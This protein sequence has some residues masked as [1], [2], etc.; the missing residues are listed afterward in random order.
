M[1]DAD[2]HAMLEDLLA[3]EQAYRP[4]SLLTGLHRLSME[5][6][7][8]F[9]AGQIPLLESHLYGSPT[10][11]AAV[12]GRAAAWAR[13]R[14]LKAEAEPAPAGGARVFRNPHQEREARI[15]WTRGPSNPQG[16][17]FLDNG[18][19][20][21][22]RSLVEALVRADPEAA[23]GALGVMARAEPGHAD[24]VDAEHLVGALDWL[25]DPRPGL[26]ERLRSELLPRAQRLLG[27]EQADAFAK[28]FRRAL[29]A[30]PA[31]QVFDPAQADQHR[32]AWLFELEDWPA[33]VEACQAAINADPAALDSPELLGR[34]ASAALKDG[35]R[36]TALLAVCQ[37]CW[38]HPEAA[39][40]W[41]EA[42]DDV[43]I[44]RRIARFWDL[45]PLLPTELFPAWLALEGHAPAP[46][47]TDQQPATSAAT[48]LLHVR[49]LRH[50]P[51]SL[52]EREWLQAEQPA[53][54]RLWLA[55]YRKRAG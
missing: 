22:R 5:D 3:R 31:A 2:L 42:T 46:P 43:E 51:E 52:A 53:L 29:A 30:Q 20:Q 6:E 4:L 44:A 38:R 14:G 39:E 49:A 12:L 13:S 16:D 33:T 10:R 25:N 19:A 45:D 54:F 17:L 41:L 1:T 9:R 48:A 55:E 7:R 15:S 40:R 27:R 32:S 26:A 11:I 36:E 24:Q 18:F 50:D 34:L 47:S 8:R 37:L 28:G 21:A 23:E 35:Q